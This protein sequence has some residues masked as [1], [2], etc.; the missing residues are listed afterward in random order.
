MDPSHT[1]RGA[2]YTTSSAF[3][4]PPLSA[5]KASFP[6]LGASSCSTSSSNTDLY[7]N[8]PFSLL[9]PSLLSPP[10]T[11]LMAGQG[12]HHSKNSSTLREKEH[13]GPSTLATPSPNSSSEISLLDS[14]LTTGHS[15]GAGTIATS[16]LEDVMAVCSSGLI[17]LT[18]SGQDAT[19]SYVPFGLKGG[20]R[21]TD[22]GPSISDVRST[23][24]DSAGCGRGTSSVC[25]TVEDSIV[26]RSPF[27]LFGLE[28]LDVL[29]ALHHRGIPLMVDQIL[30]YLT[31]KDLVRWIYT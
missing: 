21:A 6:K 23:G 28:H 22:P 13:P 9:P 26:S 1:P 8:S 2:A 24:L 11:P 14:S 29:I 19:M 17:G 15:S 27:S 30:G 20:N 10:D 31:D 25:S 12:R 3:Y 4:T 18:G 7:R 16:V 5:E